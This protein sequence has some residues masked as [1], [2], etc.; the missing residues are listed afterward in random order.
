M[1]QFTHNPAIQEPKEIIPSINKFV[2]AIDK[3]QFG[4]IPARAT[5]NGWNM[6]AD[7]INVWIDSSPT[8]NTNMPIIMFITST[9]A[10]ILI[11]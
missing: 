7:I 11:E 9:N 3:A 1:P 2:I 4:I 8:N 6:P 10:N 5:K